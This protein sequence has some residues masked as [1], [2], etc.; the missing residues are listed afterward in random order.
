MA[1]THHDVGGKR[2]LGLIFS[3]NQDCHCYDARQRSI[4]AAVAKN[5]AAVAKASAGIAKDQ[6]TSGGADINTGV[7]EE[8]LVAEEDE[9]RSTGYI[10]RM[11]GRRIGVVDPIAQSHYEVGDSMPV[12]AL[13]TTVK[14]LSLLAFMAM[15]AET[16]GASASSAV[17]LPA[18]KVV[19]VPQ[20]GDH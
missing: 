10:V 20:T 15:P 16:A 7:V 3:P 9:Y 18:P 14:G 6:P 5:Q 1:V 13:R 2:L 8:V 11:Q 12:L 4:D 19:T 17:T